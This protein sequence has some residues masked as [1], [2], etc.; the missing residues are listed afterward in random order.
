MNKRLRRLIAVPALTLA[1]TAGH[2]VSLGIADQQGDFIAT[3]AGPQAGDVD[4]LFAYS[5]FDQA[6]STFTFG[7][8]MSAPIGTTNLAQY[9]WASI[10]VSLSMATIAAHARENCGGDT[11]IT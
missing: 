8:T 9:I 11:R 3:Y 1:A 10:A 5:I 4:V 2:A 7:A 6:S